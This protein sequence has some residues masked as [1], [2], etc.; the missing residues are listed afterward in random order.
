VIHKDQ[1]FLD[2]LQP[3]EDLNEFI[4]AQSMDVV[5]AFRTYYNP[6]G[7]I[8]DHDFLS[9]IRQNDQTTAF[10]FP[11]DT[12]PHPFEAPALILTGRFDHWVGYAEAYDLLDQYPRA[13]FAVLDRAGHALVVEENSVFQALGMDWLDRVEE[14]IRDRE[15]TDPRSKI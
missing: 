10:T 13:T 5:E 1:T 11:I 6:A 3:N 9:R 15:G 8:G 14:Y 4:V 12:L 7:A 2:A